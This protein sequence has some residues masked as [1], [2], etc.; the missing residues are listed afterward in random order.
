MVRDVPPRLQNEAG[1]EFEFRVVH[2]PE[3]DNY[4][5]SEIRTYLDGEHPPAK[6]V[7]PG[8]KK[9]FRQRLAD[10]CR[11]IRMPGPAA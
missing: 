4:A 7:N 9:E 8:V 1:R 3:E 5:H 2:V 10:R 6:E 11:V